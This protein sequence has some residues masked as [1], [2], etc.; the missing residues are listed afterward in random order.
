MDKQGLVIGRSD[1]ITPLEQFEPGT[2]EIE[3]KENWITGHSS[4]G[5][6]KMWRHRWILVWQKVDGKEKCALIAS[7]GCFIEFN[8]EGDLVATKR[9]AEEVIKARSLDSFSYK[10]G[11]KLEMEEFVKFLFVHY[12]HLSHLEK[13]RSS[14][15]NQEF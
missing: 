6:I 11:H 12:L 5:L 8:E 14:L 2:T 15:E 3:L 10:Q 1:A 4:I 7:N 9:N 13:R